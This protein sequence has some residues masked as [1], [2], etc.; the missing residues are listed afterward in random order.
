MTVKDTVKDIP[1]LDKLPNCTLG[2]PPTERAIV[3]IPDLESVLIIGGCGFLGLHL[4]EE[5][6]RVAPRRPRI[7][8]F[9]IRPLDASVVSPTFYSFDPAQIESIVGDITS[10]E[11][12]AAALKRTRPQLIVHCV[13]PVHGLGKDIYYKVNVQGTENIIKQAHA[14]STVQALVYTSSAGTVFNGTDL[15][16]VDESVPFPSPAMDAYNETKAIAETA[17]LAASDKTPAVGPD[18]S[19]SLL[20]VAIRPAGIFG[21]GDRQMIPE[22]RKIPFRGQHK[23]QLGNNHYLFDVTY[24]GNVA[25]AHALAAQH[26]LAHDQAVAGQAFF[27]TNDSP[28]YFWALGRAVW[29]AD[30]FEDP[31]KVILPRSAAIA[32][33]YVSEFVSNLLGKAPGLTPFRVRTV[34]ADKYYNITKAKSILGYS[35]QTD[36]QSAIT[37]TLQWLDELDHKNQKIK[38]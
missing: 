24:V 16:N 27:V 1:G 32:I 22:L 14:D 33:G 17:V 19:N 5:F 29:K 9:D 3:S 4:I 12:V 35:P 34:C 21:P 30:G 20:T 36:L 28:I 26:L 11:D 10:P 8:V 31:P 18:F 6:W 13:S 23:F 15:K 7:A 38:A 25:Y 2:V 37:Q